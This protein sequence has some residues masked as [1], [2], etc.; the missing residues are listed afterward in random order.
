MEFWYSLSLQIRL[1]INTLSTSWYL[2]CWPMWVIWNVS[3]LF[4]YQSFF[5]KSLKADFEIAMLWSVHMKRK[6]DSMLQ[7]IYCSTKA[8]SIIS[9]QHTNFWINNSIL[10][11]LY[12]YETRTKIYTFLPFYCNIIIIC[13]NWNSF[14]WFKSL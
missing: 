14:L 3:H 12:R 5:F 8:C 9:N 7:L 6:L 2:V 4:I 10:F 1:D 13:I 11:S